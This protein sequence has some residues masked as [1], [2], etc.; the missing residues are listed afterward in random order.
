MTEFKSQKEL[1]TEK[2]RKRFHSLSKPRE[3]ANWSTMCDN[4]IVGGKK[5]KRR[6]REMMLESLESW[7]VVTS[8]KKMIGR[9]QVLTVPNQCLCNLQAKFTQQVSRDFTKR[10]WLP[11]RLPYFPY[12]IPELQKSCLN[13]NPSCPRTLTLTLTLTTCQLT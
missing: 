11:S 6:P 10:T 2:R 9:T 13:D 1:A 5:G 7:H 8:V 3:G 12:M 4:G